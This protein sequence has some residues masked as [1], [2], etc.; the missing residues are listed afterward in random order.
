M[1][2]HKS[3]A[4]LRPVKDLYAVYPVHIELFRGRFNL[5][6]TEMTALLGITSPQDW[7]KMKSTPGERVKNPVTCALLR[8]YNENPEW[9]SEM[10]AF[11]RALK[12]LY[13]MLRKREGYT[14][15]SAI[16][17]ITQLYD[18]S[19]SVLRKWYKGASRPTL[20]AL[21]LSEIVNQLGYRDLQAFV[22]DARLSTIPQVE[23]KEVKVFLGP[24]DEELYKVEGNDAVYTFEEVL[25]FCAVPGARRPRQE[26][27]SSPAKV[28]TT[29][30]VLPKQGVGADDEDDAVRQASRMASRLSWRPKSNRSVS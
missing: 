29:E 7:H 27:A 22:R 11:R 19:E 24:N 18:K 12:R 20:A 28:D 25:K 26:V 3:S 21:Q 23:G 15:A 5:K 14:S 17:A 2:E 16:Y 13:R 1:S 8:A 9:L 10:G 30:S 6:V 4:N